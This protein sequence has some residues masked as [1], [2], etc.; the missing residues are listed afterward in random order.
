M[1]KEYES[2]T[3]P[4]KRCARE[5]ELR[6]PMPIYEAAVAAAEE[7]GETIEVAGTCPDCRK[8]DPFLRMLDEANIPT[9]GRD[10]ARKINR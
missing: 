9:V 6:L 7:D 4:C 1:S 3:I 8:D 10:C 2:I 5:F